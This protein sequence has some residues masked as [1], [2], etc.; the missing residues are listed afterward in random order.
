MAD[1]GPLA[2]RKAAHTSWAKTPDRAART[3]PARQA[4]RDTFLDKVD[5]EKR[6]SPR[7]RAKAAEN[8]RIA[9]YIELSER[10]KQIRAE[11]RKGRTAERRDGGAA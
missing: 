1:S 5:P 8:A 6:M 11:R 3:A 2:S 7:D 4:F 10:S 9:F